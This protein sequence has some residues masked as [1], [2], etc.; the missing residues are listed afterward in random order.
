MTHD[1]LGGREGEASSRLD[2]GREVGERLLFLETGFSVVGHVL[3]Y[4]G[5]EG[6]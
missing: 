6:K 5:K 3:F 1:V 4:L 2:V